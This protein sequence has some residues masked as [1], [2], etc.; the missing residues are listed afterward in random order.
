MNINDQRAKIDVKD[1]FEANGEFK[2]EG[3]ELF[4]RK[5]TGYVSF[6]RGENPYTF[7]YR[8]YPSLFAPNSTFPTIP[9]PLYQ[10]NG[11]RIRDE[12]RERIL[13][14]YLTK[15]GNCNR[16]GVCQYCDYRYILYFLKNKNMNITTKKGKTREM[17]S[18]GYDEIWIYFITD[19]FGIFDYFLSK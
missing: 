18:F 7:P 16:C 8:I 14:L 3:R 17:R 12:N 6:V 11:K 5:V 15:I 10:M 4:I 1:I 19:P 13:S 9:Y 2:K